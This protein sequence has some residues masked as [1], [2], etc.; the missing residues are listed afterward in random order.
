M[1]GVFSL[2]LINEL[3]HPPALIHNENICM[4]LNFNS[5]VLVFLFTI[6]IAAQDDAKPQSQGGLS[7]EELAKANNPWAD[8]ID[9]NI[10]YYFR[11]SSNKIEGVVF[12]FF[13][14]PQ[15][16][17]LSRVTVEPNFQIYGTVNMQF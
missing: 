11:P 7:A 2:K 10:Q 3:N 1:P 6:P 12:N 8:L 16:S 13:I 17:I 4:K 5:L 15:P 14:E 9:F